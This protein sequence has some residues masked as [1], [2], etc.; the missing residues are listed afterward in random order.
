MPSISL[1]FLKSRVAKT[2]AK[3][4]IWKA[5][6][7]DLLQSVQGNIGNATPGSR[8]WPKK[9]QD[10]EVGVRLDWGEKFQKDG[11]WF[12]NLVLQFN[13]DA[14]NPAINE[15]AKK[16]THAK[17]AIV[18]V[19]MSTD[20]KKLHPEVTVEDFKPVVAEGV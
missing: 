7:K 6:E 4:K 12:R 2:F 3:K 10:K 5:M 11:D 19:P 1:N 8:A 16:G 15:L 20:G 9:T 18:G 13:K 17:R 14:E